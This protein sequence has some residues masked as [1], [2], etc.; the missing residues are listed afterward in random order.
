[1][2]YMIE[3]S[4]TWVDRNKAAL[5]KEQVEYEQRANNLINKQNEAYLRD[6]AL[7]VFR[8][9]AKNYLVCQSMYNLLEKCINTSDNNQVLIGKNLIESFVLEEGADN[10]LTR[11]SVK[12]PYLASVSNIIRESYTRI[13]EGC[14]ECNDQKSFTI[15]PS[16]KNN[17]Y[18]KLQGLS[19]T[20]I[21]DKIN[22]NVTKS[23][24]EFVDSYVQDK[25]KMEETA[26]KLADKLDN[27]KKISMD[28]EEEI[29]Q[30]YVNMY[31]YYNESL[32]NNR[33]RNILEE[34]TRRLSHKTLTEDTSLISLK[35]NNRPNMKTIID[36]ATTMYTFLEMVS[37]AKMKDINETYIQ[38]VLDSIH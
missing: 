22:D 35:E 3:N 27:A 5:Y 37:V 36:C 33:K 38:N 24:E 15:K 12:T 26:Q 30:E 1:M 29:K 20:R 28:S 16:E 32:I 7:Q 8:E 18:D 19:V 31:K 21:V 2:S 17:F 11:W 10:L 23:T 4:M 25:L 13:M 14:N 34:I 9:D 6:K